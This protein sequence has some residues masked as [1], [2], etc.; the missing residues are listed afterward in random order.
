MVQY[1]FWKLVSFPY[2]IKETNL[3]KAK[4]MI[5]RY[6]NAF[7]LVVQQLVKCLKKLAYGETK[8]SQSYCR[9]AGYANIKSLVRNHDQQNFNPLIVTENSIKG[10]IYQD[11]LDMFFHSTVTI[12]ILQSSY[13]RK[14]AK[15]LPGIWMCRTV[16]KKCF[17]KLDLT[18]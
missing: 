17:W 12:Y 13:S 10:A 4:K 18:R 7:S 11:M 1:H 15:L 14:V 2:K 8:P 5:L 9:R 3:K 6:C 16:W